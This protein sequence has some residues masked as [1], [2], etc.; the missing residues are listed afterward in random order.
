MFSMSWIYS[1]GLIT[2][3]LLTLFFTP[4]VKKVAIKIGAVDQPNERKI[5][6]EPMP[7]MGGVAIYLAYVLTYIGVVYFTDAVATNVGYALLLG[8]AIIV[9]TGIFDDIYELSPKTK[10]FGQL[11]A[12]GVAMYF[13]LRIQVVSLP[14]ME[15]SLRIGWLGIPLTIL[16][17]IG[18]T[19]AINL[20]DGL[21]GLASGVSG[22]ASLALFFVS[23][24]IGNTMLA[25][26]SIILVGSVL[27]F[28]RFNFYPAKIFMG[29]SGSLFLGFFLA[30]ISLLELKQVTL[31]SFVI[32][33]LVL[34][35]PISDTLYAMIRRKLNG[36]SISTADKLHL[37]HRLLAMGLSHRKAVLL[38]YLISAIF[39][40][41]A[42]V[43]THGALW[44]AILA[45]ASYLLFF[46]IFAE[47]IGMMKQEHRPVL[48][49]M[50]KISGLFKRDKA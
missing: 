25:L 47:A 4:V 50:S 1:I 2:A 31:V 27:G 41:L 10:V 16:W 32:P 46:E 42:I 6:Q 43:I 49:L 20:I 48:K 26:M 36:Q 28:L 15:E 17:I 39:A 7:R 37:H 21:D 44:W 13:G 40:F 34:A 9:I 14:F 5:H 24:S 30:V 18:I 12:A 33:M 8:G 35:V 3:F 29:D 23:V 45:F 11:L 19:N 38:I 22:I